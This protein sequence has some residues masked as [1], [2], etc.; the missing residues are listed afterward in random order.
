MFCDFWTHKPCTGLTNEVFTFLT[1]TAKATGNVQYI[2]TACTSTATSINKKINAL[3]KDLRV[4]EGRVEDNTQDIQKVKEKVED[5]QKKL[6]DINTMQASTSMAA[7]DSVFHEIKE[8]EN[9]KNNI[10]IHGIPE[11]DCDDNLARKKHD[12]DNLEEILDIVK[13]RVKQDDIKYMNRIGEK[14]EKDRPLLVCFRKQDQKLQVI[15]NSRLLKNSTRSDVSIIPDLTKRQRNEEDALRKEMEKRNA[16]LEGEDF[17]NSE[18]RLVGIRGERKLVKGKKNPRN[19]GGD[20]GRENLRA[21]SGSLRPR[22]TSSRD[23][24]PNLIPLGDRR[25]AEKRKKEV[26]DLAR[27]QKKARDD[28]LQAGEEGMEEGEVTEEEI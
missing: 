20:Q 26:E 3:D 10:V 1:K 23:M 5:I 19:W 9:R 17:L 4:V 18:W 21:R 24:N 16:E 7:Q 11:L 14:K 12:I 8:R 15:E 28:M 22:H 27:Q 13:S 2:C 6:P 25:A